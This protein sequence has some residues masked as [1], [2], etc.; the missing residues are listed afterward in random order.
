MPQAI[1]P[2]P[3]R[4]TYAAMSI[5]LIWHTF[6]MVIGPAPANLIVGTARWLAQP[7]LTFFGLQNEWGFFAPTV[8]P[9]YRFS[10]VIEDAAGEKHTFTPADSLNNLYPDSIWKRDHYTMIMTMP[11][12]YGDAAGADL[13]LEHASLNPANVTLL[14]IEQ[15]EFRP[16]DLRKGK[17]PTDAEF[18]K[19]KTLR[20]VTCP[21]R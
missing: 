3:K 11:E 6:V 16:G 14:E 15:K 19:E 17:R 1:R 9:G 13:C 12:V 7:Y 20:T 2:G 4:L 5:L 18:A 8:S 10:Y 21:G